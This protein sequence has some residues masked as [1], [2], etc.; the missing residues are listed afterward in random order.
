MT[1]LG[2]NVIT[3]ILFYVISAVVRYCYHWCSYSAQRLW[4]TLLDST[5]KLARDHAVLGELCGGQISN[6]LT[7][8]TDDIQRI[9][10]KV[11]SLLSLYSGLFL[12]Y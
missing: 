6:R 7:E 9:Y 2:Q 3:V 11:S 5:R 4:L 12:V 1:Q 8:L 10:K